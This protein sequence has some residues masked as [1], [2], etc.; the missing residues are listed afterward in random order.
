MDEGQ[1]F[2]ILHR[3]QFSSKF[4]TTI[5]FLF[6]SFYKCTSVYHLSPPPFST[7]F[8]MWGK[9]QILEKKNLKTILLK[10]SFSLKKKNKNLL[11]KKK[12][13]KKIL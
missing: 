12:E 9:K 1:V 8:H 5:F 4:Q 10:K 2:I 3:F 6:N 11:K 7:L 13:K